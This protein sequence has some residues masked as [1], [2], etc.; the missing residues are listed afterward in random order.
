VPP[1][2]NGAGWAD[3][4]VGMRRRIVLWRGADKVLSLVLHV[5]IKCIYMFTIVLLVR[6]CITL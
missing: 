3:D 6:E 4:K 5:A 1:W 2:G